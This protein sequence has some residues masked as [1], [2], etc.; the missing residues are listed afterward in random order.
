MSP[1]LA[2]PKKDPP[3]PECGGAMSI[4]LTEPVEQTDSERPTYECPVCHFTET[5]VVAIT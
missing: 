4:V 3:C 5:I 2:D 1:R